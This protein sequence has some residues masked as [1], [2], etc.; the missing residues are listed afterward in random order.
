MVRRARELL[1]RPHWPAGSTDSQAAQRLA[2]DLKNLREFNLLTKLSKRVIRV[3]P[4]ATTVRRLHA[5]A[6]IETG[7]ATAAIA[8]AQ[9]ALEGLPESDEEWSELAGLI[10]RAYKQIAID[11]R[12]PHCIESR[13]ALAH[14]LDAYRKPYERNP[15]NT[16]HAINLVAV[17]TFAKRSGV[18]VPT[19]F[20]TTQPAPSNQS[21]TDRMKHIKLNHA[22]EL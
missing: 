4:N 14:A 16:W 2:N 11:T 5:Q 3:Q 20:D 9:K 19:A 8:V 21:R 12:D 6:L 17:F 13:E 1:Q 22:T 18:T 10:G 7:Q 15:N